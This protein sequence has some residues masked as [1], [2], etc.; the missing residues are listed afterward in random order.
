[1]L[2]GYIS[3]LPLFIYGRPFCMDAFH[4]GLLIATHAIG[5]CILTGL[6]SFF[7]SLNLDKTYVYPIIGLIGFMGELVIFALAQQFWLLYIGTF[8]K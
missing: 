6:I 1:M 2:F 4:V 3:I 7:K 8:I 5:A